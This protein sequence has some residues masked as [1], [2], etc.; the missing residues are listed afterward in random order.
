[1]SLRNVHLGDIVWWHHDLVPGLFDSELCSS[2]YLP[3]PQDSAS[4]R[5]IPPWVKNA[6]ESD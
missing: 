5:F 2:L 4:V 6:M 3:H 1:M